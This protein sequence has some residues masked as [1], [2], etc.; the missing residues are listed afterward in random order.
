V[1]TRVSGHLD[2][3]TFHRLSGEEAARRSGEAILVATTDEHGRPHPA[4]LS[5]GE[6]RAVTPDILRLVV[7]A[8]STTSRNL[9]TRAAI[10]LCLVTAAEGALY[11][12][13]RARP[14]PATVLTKGGQAAYEARIEEV[15]ADAPAAGEAARLTG[16]ITFVSEDPP[17]RA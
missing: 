13:A 10:T 11:V 8:G 6:V 16:G 4:L 3:A 14:L 7:A 12:K 9:D 17:R 2:D 5:Y 1:S 15:L